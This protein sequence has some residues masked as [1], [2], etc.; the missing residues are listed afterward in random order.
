[1]PTNET[2]R[3]EFES[4]LRINEN[5]LDR[6]L[7]EHAEL[8]W[9]VSKGRNLAFSLRDSQKKLVDEVEGRAASRI[10]K[11]AVADGTK[12]TEAKVAERVPRDEELK[13]AQERLIELN[14]EANDW[15]SLREAIKQRGYM[16]TA[17]VEMVVAGH[18]A[19]NAVRGESATK[20]SDAAYDRNSDA[21]HRKR[22]EKRER[23]ERE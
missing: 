1:M 19:K 15:D 8:Y 21:L 18:F 9:H 14:R 13:A 6:E 7:V 10:R 22:L 3:E 17:L 2:S 23:R 5:S 12:I 16:L 20:I 11:K 4:R